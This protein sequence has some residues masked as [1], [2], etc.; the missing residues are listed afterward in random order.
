VGVF[1]RV[2]GCAW[3]FYP[4]RY[5]LANALHPPAA[6]SI[7]ADLPNSIDPRGLLTFGLAGIGLLILAMLMGRSPNFSG[8]LSI[9]GTVLGILLILVYLGRLIIL[10]PANPFVLYPAA[11]TGCLINP[12]FNLWLGRVLGRSK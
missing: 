4:R 6:A 7:A 2:E 12:A 3:L 10:D 8:G 5:D 9:L 11:L 1:A